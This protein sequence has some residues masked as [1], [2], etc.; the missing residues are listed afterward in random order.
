MKS[1]TGTIPF[2]LLP[3]KPTSHLPRSR[4]PAHRPF[5]IGFISHGV[6]TTLTFPLSISAPKY[7]RSRGF[8]VRSA[9]KVM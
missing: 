3:T 9:G 2:V 1:T 7:S 5:Q 6:Y 8:H 4:S